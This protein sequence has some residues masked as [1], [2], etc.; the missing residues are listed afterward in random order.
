LTIKDDGQETVFVIP[1]PESAP[2]AALA[3]DATK[4]FLGLAAAW[5]RL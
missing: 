3:A 2:F 1:Y 4:A 5:Q